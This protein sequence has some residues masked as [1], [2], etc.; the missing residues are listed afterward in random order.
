M[1]DPLAPHV[2]EVKRIV[3]NP[4]RFP[5]DMS[6]LL[7]HLYIGTY[8]DAVEVET[9]KRHGITHIVNCVEVTANCKHPYQT[10]MS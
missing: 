2:A 6:K 8:S 9:L 10:G 1:D 5:K 4:T 3:A 7:D